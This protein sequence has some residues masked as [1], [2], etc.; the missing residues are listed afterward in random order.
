MSSSSIRAT[1]VAAPALPGLDI[2]GPGGT[3]PVASSD[4]RRACMERAGKLL[5][6]RAR[7]EREL[8]ERLAGAGFDDATVEATM[9]RLRELRLV[10]DEDFARRWVEERSG[11]KGLGPA[12]LRSELAL[13][14]VD[15]S[16]IDAALTPAVDD[17]EARAKAFAATLVRRVARKPLQAQASSLWQMLRR[18]GYSAEACEVAV[19]A[20]LPPEGWD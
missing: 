2:Q 8:S 15:P 19:K 13:K 11:R 12:R 18:K 1:D 16:T 7:S 14:G 6:T 10:D 5:A 20:V 4:E 3:L 9:D 17:E